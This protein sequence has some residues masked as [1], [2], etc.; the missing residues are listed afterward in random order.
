MIDWTVG[1]LA[2]TLGIPKDRIR[3]MSPFIGG[4]L[5]L[6]SDAVL[7]ALGTRA[8]GRPVKVALPRPLVANNT[9]HRPATIQRIRI[10]ATSDGRITAISHESWSGN[11]AGG[12]PENAIQQ[13][14]LLYGGANRMMAKRPAVLDLPEGNANVVFQLRFPSGVLAHCSASYGYADTKRIMVQ[15]SEASLK[16]NLVADYYEHKLTVTKGKIEEEIK[17]QEGNQFALEMDYLAQSIQEDQ[18]PKTPGEEGLQDI[19]LMQA[20]YEAARLGK[21][22][23]LE[24]RIPDVVADAPRLRQCPA[25]LQ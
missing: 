3:L 21:A 20:I 12:K 13:T 19:R 10:G 4:K 24:P 14:R 16:L 15:G 9:T 23:K 8:A 5:F 6:R 1:D 7:A 25:V 18:P 2:G 11:L 22:V 17:V